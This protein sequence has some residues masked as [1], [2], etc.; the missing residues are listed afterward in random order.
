MLPLQNELVVPLPSLVVELD[1]ESS[2]WLHLF[3]SAF[4]SDDG[5]TLLQGGAHV[6]ELAAN[7]L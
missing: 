6:S 5:Q 1:G 4:G 3:Q 7:P 2:N